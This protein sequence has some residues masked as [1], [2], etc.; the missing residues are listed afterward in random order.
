[1]VVAGSWLGLGADRPWTKEEHYKLARI[2]VDIPN[3][4]DLEW[5]LDVKKST[6]SPPS[7]LRPRLKA[8]ANDV[9]KAGSR[10]LRPSWRDGQA[11]R[12]PAHSAHLAIF[13]Q[14]RACFPYRIER[15]HPFV[16]RA[17]ETDPEQKAVVKALLRLLEETVPVAQ[18][19]L[20]TAERG[21]VMPSPFAG[22]QERELREI[23]EMLYEG[24]LQ[25]G[26]S[27]TAARDR[28]AVIEPFNEHPELLASLLEGECWI[29]G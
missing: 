23:L 28:V 6:A 21:E 8:L 25:Q 3:T 26:L 10:G 22:S 27:P 20:D 17:L 2:R 24:F 12:C 19:W 5:R 9:R 29:P 1:M 16:K 11:R 15:T 4:M 18:I 7:P 13:H 14:A